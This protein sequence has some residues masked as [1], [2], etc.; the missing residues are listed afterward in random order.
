MGA[1]ILSLLVI[2]LQADAKICTQIWRFVCTDESSLCNLDRQ[3]LSS[4]F[5]CQQKHTQAQLVTTCLSKLFSTHDCLM[6]LSGS[7]EFLEPFWVLFGIQPL[8]S[9]VQYLVADSF[10]W[11]PIQPL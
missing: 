4:Y 10:H 1:G 11:C 9:K 6:Q 7:P 3:E 5:L 2:N 8:A